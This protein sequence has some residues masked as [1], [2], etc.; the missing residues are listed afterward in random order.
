MRNTIIGIA[1]FFL[2][3][4]TAAWEPMGPPGGKLDELAVAISNEDIIYVN[5][6]YPL[7][8]IYK[9]V[10]AG[11]AWSR[12]N[13]GINFSSLVVDPTNPDI[14][15]AGGGY[16]NAYK[17]ING[18]L[19]WTRY[20]ISGSI[21]ALLVHPILNTMVFAVGQVS[22]GAKNVAAFFKSTNGGVTWSTVNLDT[23][24]GLANCLTLDNNNP[25]IIYV[26][27]YSWSPLPL[28]RVYKSTNGGTSFLSTSVGLI[29]GDQ[30]Y[31][32]A[33]HPT[34]DNF[35]YAA[36]GECIYRSTDGGIF[37]TQTFAN[38]IASLSTTPV[39]PDHVYAGGD[40]CVY[41]STDAGATWAVSGT[42]L[43]GKGIRGLFASR[44]QA[45]KFYATNGAGFF[46][47]TNGGLNWFASNS[48]INSADIG[49]FAISRSAPSTIYVEFK[50]VGIYKTTDGGSSW[51]KLPDFLSCGNICALCIHNTDANTLF[52]LE[53]AG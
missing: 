11:V 37:W 3:F 43:Y 36:T 28:P 52:A 27:G 39:L 29:A 17:S 47:T 35:V 24:S 38:A 7:A 45:T 25:N 32:I 51:T 41:K 34:D 22:A 1:I 23:A 4:S 18:G 48:G 10:D 53:G 30:V 46:K 16:G 6:Y 49:T 44:N 40:T 2:S 12:I 5:P 26:G 50:D 20:S 8:C 9:S 14:V 42:G 19:N 21:S 15:Y 31:S 33:A 13:V